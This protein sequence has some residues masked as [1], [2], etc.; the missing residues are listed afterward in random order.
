MNAVEEIAG[1]VP[2]IPIEYK[3]IL[4]DGG[5]FWDDVNGGYLLEDLVLAARREETAWVQSEGFYEMVQMQ[6]GADAGRKLWD[7]HFRCVVELAEGF[8][9]LSRGV[10]SA[11]RDTGGRRERWCSSVA[12]P[13]HAVVKAIPESERIVEQIAQLVPVLQM[14]REIVGVVQLVLVE[15]IRDRIAD[16]MVDIPVPPVMEENMEAVQE[17]MR[18]VSRERVQQRVDEQLVEVLVPQVF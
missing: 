9:V 16:Q 4:S 18:L 2:E 5:G 17:V 15:R 8:V 6:G 13:E 12:D 14:M 1:P 10:G 7:L 11:G 3:Q